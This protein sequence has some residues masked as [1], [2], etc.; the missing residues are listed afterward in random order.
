MIRTSADELCQALEKERGMQ[1]TLSALCSKLKLR[2]RDVEPMVKAL[3]ERGLIEIIYPVNVLGSPTIRLK[4]VMQAKEPLLPRGREMVSYSVE[5]SGV[6]AGVSILD[7]KEEPR[8]VYVLDIPSVG[9]YTEVLMESIRDELAREMPVQ[10]EEIV[11]ARKAL[12]L[13]EKF[14]DTAAEKLSEKIPDI[15]EKNKHILA[16]LL[17]HRMYGLGDIEML[18]ADDMLEE[19]VVNGS[20][21]PISVYHRK[22]GWLKTN[23][24]IPT[25]EDIYNYASQIGR[26]SGRDITLLAPIMDAHLA[27][28]DR[29]AATLYPIS[30]CGDTLTIR[31]F[32]REPWTIID[33]IDPK[34]NTLNSEMAAFL[35]QAIQYEMNILISG[36]TASGKTS[37]LNTLCALIPPS[38]RNITIEDTRE[39]NL[40]S[41]LRFNWVPLIT[42]QPNPEGKGEVK[43]LDLMV[44][45]LRLRPDRIIVGEV[46]RRREAEVLFEAMH[47]GHAVYSTIHADTAQQVLRRLTHPPFELPV[48]ELQSLHLILVMYRDR[49]RGLRRVY[50]VSEVGAASA[51]EATLTS[52]YRWRAR[53]DAFE[54]VGEAARVMEELNLHA[55]MSA[56]EIKADI[57]RKKKVLEWMLRHDVRSVEQVGSVMSVYYKSPDVIEHAAEKDIHPKKVL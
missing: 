39:L 29:V 52:I 20:A 45:S 22:Y 13:K 37:M 48:T 27:T 33:F 21:Q 38:S 12:A 10:V 5:A 47:T 31:R 3:A 18:M 43:M 57:M 15:T 51:E 30:T 14:F 28:G 4:R 6:P 41:Y 9:P 19:I 25:E 34:L 40:P 1:A 53:Q 2:P 50:E 44:T 55:G 8:P 56:D 17:L 16:G 36:G 49:R 35:W 11:D 32:A 42:R 46:R 7:V 24:Y 54:R 26:K 23:I